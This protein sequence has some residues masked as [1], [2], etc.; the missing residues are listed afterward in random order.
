M[1]TTFP[2]A[3]GNCHSQPPR[4]AAGLSAKRCCCLWR[5]S[6]VQELCQ[7]RVKS[8]LRNPK[9]SV[10]STPRRARAT[11]ERV[12]GRK[13]LAAE[14]PAAHDHDARHIPSRHHIL[15]RP[16][17]PQ[18]PV[19]AATAPHPRH[20]TPCPPSAPRIW[21]GHSPTRAA[22]T[23]RR[24]AP[25]RAQSQR[26]HQGG[27]SGTCLDALEVLDLAE[28]GHVLFE[29]R[30]DPREARLAA[31]RREETLAKRDDAPVGELHGLRRQRGIR[32]QNSSRRGNCP[33]PA[34]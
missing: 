4:R 10:L 29:R 2:A 19:R 15:P 18:R 5:A 28:V 3:P 12:G 6:T 17:R 14:K 22:P 16:A 23:P 30:R 31:A 1:S 13:C 34:S 32:L 8:E 7:Y 21:A 9:A 27:A 11:P 26:R 25:R 33:N 20:V 24:A